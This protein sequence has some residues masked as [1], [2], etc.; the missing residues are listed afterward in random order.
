MVKIDFKKNSEIFRLPQSNNADFAGLGS[1]DGH[2]KGCG[3]CGSGIRCYNGWVFMEHAGSEGEGDICAVLDSC[4]GNVMDRRER[5]S[6]WSPLSYCGCSLQQTSKLGRTPLVYWQQ[7][8]KLDKE[9]HISLVMD[10]FGC[11]QGGVP[12]YLPYTRYWRSHAADK[13]AVLVVHHFIVLHILRHSHIV[14]EVS[15]A[16]LY[17][18]EFHDGRFRNS[19]FV[20]MDYCNP[21]RQT[22]ATCNPNV[23]VRGTG[24]L[25]CRDHGFFPYLFVRF[26]GAFHCESH[27][28][29]LLQ[30]GC[31][32]CKSDHF[33]D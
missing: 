9:V 1:H 26:G 32:P 24:C 10:R 12:Q 16:V 17:R 14:S 7:L 19:R 29:N 4:A 5:Q 33:V 15:F 22:C 23:Q 3:S 28:Y 18:I 6:S 31:M 30:V 11:F 25:L 21:A 13:G 2:P 27:I 8:E 20:A